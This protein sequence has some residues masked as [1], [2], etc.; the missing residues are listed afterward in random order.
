MQHPDRATMERA[1]ELAKESFK[2]GDYAVAALIILDG[3]IIAEATTTIAREQDATC[4]AEINAIRQASKVL[5]SKRLTNC[6]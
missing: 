2:E 5:K 6:H 1:I 4:H 3:K